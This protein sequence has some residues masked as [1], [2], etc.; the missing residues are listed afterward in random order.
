MEIA[1][2]VLEFV[3][4]LAWPTVTITAFLVFKKE[5]RALISRVRHADLPGGIT[6]DFPHEIAEAKRLSEKVESAAAPTN[7]K[8]G[9]AIPLTEANA[10]MIQLGL[11]PSPSGLDMSYYRNLA[12]QDPTLALA[13]LRIEIDILAKNLANG[14]KVST[15]HQD[16]GTRLLRKLFDA[17]AITSEQMQLGMKV[18]Q[19]CNAAVHGTA[20]SRE[21]AEAVIDIAAVLSDHYLAWLSWGFEDGWQPTALR[22]EAKNTG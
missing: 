21:D 8:A 5:L 15:N 22:T 12:Q 1:K 9:P 11:R 14:F 4:A 6:L 13:G 3:K 10:R 19:M 2:L 18:L 17:S 20:V 7:R 16:S